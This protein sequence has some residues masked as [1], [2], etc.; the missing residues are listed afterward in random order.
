MSPFT[1]LGTIKL[2][3]S[4]EILHQIKFGIA[5]KKNKIEIVSFLRLMTKVHKFSGNEESDQ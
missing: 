3:R 4:Y 5:K 2:D 1:S